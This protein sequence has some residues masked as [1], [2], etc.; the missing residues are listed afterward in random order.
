MLDAVAVCGGAEHHSRS[1]DRRN[2][3]VLPGVTVEVASPALIE[4]SRTAVTNADGRYSIV[5]LRPGDLCGDVRADR[6]SI[7]SSGK[8][9]NWPRTSACRSTRSCRSAPSR[10]RSPSRARHRSSTSS[11]PPAAGAHA[12]H[13]RCAADRAI[14]SLGGRDCPDGQVIP[15]RGRRYQR[16]AG[17]LSQLPRQELR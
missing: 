5:D 2:R 7:R 6:A 8:G 10:K 12:R 3:R 13:A 11:R 16:R 9:S 17:R 15:P 14:V 4:K 1:G